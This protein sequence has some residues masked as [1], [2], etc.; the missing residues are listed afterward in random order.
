MKKWEARNPKFREYTEYKIGKNKFMAMMGFKI[1]TIEPGYLE[2][3]LAFEEMHEQQNGYLHG[4]V[5][6]TI[7]DMIQGFAAYTMVEDGQQV[8]TVEAKISY[9]NPGI[10]KH[11]YSRGGVVKPGKRFHF[12]EAEVYYKKENGKE[13]IVAKGSATM[14]VI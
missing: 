2:G 13:V 3:E 14:A 8:F 9:Y 11:F 10:A 5:T 7:L 1:T 6:S 12:C 4:G